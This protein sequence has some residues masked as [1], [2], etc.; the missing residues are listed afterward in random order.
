MNPHI[1]WFITAFSRLNFSRDIGLNINPISISE[2]VLYASSI[3][4]PYSVEF[5]ID[6]VQAMDSE[7]MKRIQET[8]SNS[9]QDLKI[10][11]GNIS[12][13]PGAHLG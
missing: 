11:Q 8:K 3:L 2:I 9:E 1:E 4:H 6:V 10:N 13:T 5:V 7:Y 12:G